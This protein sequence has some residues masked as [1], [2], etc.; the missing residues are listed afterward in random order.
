M[1][2]IHRTRWARRVMRSDA[3]AHAVE[4]PEAYLNRMKRVKEAQGKT[5]GVRRQNG[6]RCMSEES[7]AVRLF[8][9]LAPVSQLQLECSN[10]R[11]GVR[12]EGFEILCWRHSLLQNR[13]PAYRDKV[14]N[15]ISVNRYLSR[16][17]CARS[18]RA[19]MQT[20]KCFPVGAGELQNHLFFRTTTGAMTQ[21]VTNRFPKP[22]LWNQFCEYDAHIESLPLG[23]DLAN[24]FRRPSAL[25]SGPEFTS[26]LAT[27]P[28]RLSFDRRTRTGAL[29]SAARSEL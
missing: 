6:D 3:S 5:T 29:F 18:G 1:A 21:E 22:E 2:R 27:N 15:A 13:L 12:D 4:R 25:D 10:H 11:F 19:V 20:G 24:F 23:K 14:C 26:F 7:I 9:S 16:Q 17:G 28:S 8:K